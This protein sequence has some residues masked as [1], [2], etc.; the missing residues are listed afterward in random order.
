MDW[1]ELVDKFLGALLFGFALVSIGSGIYAVHDAQSDLE[2]LRH[3]PQFR[4]RRLLVERE[5]RAFQVGLVVGI[6]LLVIAIQIQL[7]WLD[8][9]WRIFIGRLALV[10]VAVLLVVALVRVI[11]D[12]HQALRLVR[13]EKEESRGSESS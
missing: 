1:L 4:V 7:P 5:L 11:R 9:P 8:L 3:F 13:R 12:K 10:I 6:L 2:I